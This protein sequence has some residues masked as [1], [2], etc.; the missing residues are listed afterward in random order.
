MPNQPH[1]GAYLYRI[2]LTA[3]LGGLLFGYDTG[4]ISGAEIYL[5]NFFH[6]TPA[7]EGW[8]VASALVGCI[9]GA[10]LAAPVSERFGRR[11]ALL[12]AALF[13]AFSAVG[14]AIPSNLGQ[15]ALARI[16]GGVAVGWASILC[17]MYIAE[18][19]PPR[20]RG[21]LVSW[22]QMAIISGF[23]VV[24][25]VNAWISHM[26]SGEWNL[27]VGWRWMFGSETLPALLFFFLLFLVPESPR[28]L[29]RAGR[30]EEAL[31]V[32]EKTSRGEDVG[33]EMV[34]I[35]A[36]LRR[37]SAGWKDLLLPGM[38]KILWIGL[39]LSILQQWTGIN[40]IM[41]F[42]P[43]IFEKAGIPKE[44][45]ILR[46]VLVGVV[47]VSAT[48]VAIRFVDRWGR[49]PL[50]LAA[51]AGMGASMAFLG[52]ALVLGVGGFW[53]VLF[54]LVYVAFFGVAMGP[55]VWVLLSEIFPNRVRDAAMAVCVMALWIANFMVTQF[56][57]P[58]LEK[59][60]GWTFFFYS[61]MCLVCFFFVKSLVPETKGKSL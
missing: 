24:F 38:A 14:S 35:R 56:F 11:K 7:Q 16:L 22:N 4:V 37:K 52:G 43:R 61:F 2:T 55:V 1:G 44:A 29:V 54:A 3:T 48:L 39:G 50:M 33:K 45:A 27:Q 34:E 42:S 51:A 26:K 32:L 46:T 58:M 8:A 18:I 12:A 10:P 47:Q 31:V 17:P 25:L 57:P 53:V 20:M 21:R 9:L 28:W 49:K 19:S 13:F 41:Y 15:F 36:S 23:L 30:E 40:T 59:L 6:L 60:G 5:R